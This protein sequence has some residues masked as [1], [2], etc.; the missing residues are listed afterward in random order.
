MEFFLLKFLFFS[1]SLYGLNLNLQF[2]FVFK[3]LKLTSHRVPFSG[4]EEQE[5]DDDI[6]F[7]IYYTGGGV[8]YVTDSGG[9]GIAGGGI[10][11][12]NKLKTANQYTFFAIFRSAR[13]S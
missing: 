8:G 7:T 13:T 1:I 12:Y 10:T 5:E 4:E 3:E 11:Q 2:D 9:G 6:V